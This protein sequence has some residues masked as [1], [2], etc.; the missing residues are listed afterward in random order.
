MSWSSPSG[1]GV[2]NP[3]ALARNTGLIPGP[4]TRI[5]HAME[6]L[7]HTPWLEIAHVPKLK[8]L[9]LNEDSVQEK[10]THAH[11]R[12]PR[13]CFLKKYVLFYFPLLFL[14]HLS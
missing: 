11:N 14:I 3:S 5:P 6:Q 2:K 8:A 12:F 13:F 9:L 7:S 4:R 1:P 10:S